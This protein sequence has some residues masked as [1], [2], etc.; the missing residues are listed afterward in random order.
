MPIPGFGISHS[1]P[2]HTTPPLPFGHYCFRR[3]PFGIISAPE[4]FQR[5]MS[6]ILADLE[7]VVGLMDDILIYG[8]T[9]EQHD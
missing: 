7:G 8:E 4:H 2:G 6:E 3:L 9:Q 5:R 1:L